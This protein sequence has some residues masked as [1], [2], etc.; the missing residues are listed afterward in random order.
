MAMHN[1]MHPGEFIRDVFLEP[2][3][4]STTKL[5][6]A[7]QVD[8]S[9]VSRILNGKATITPEMAIRLSASLGRSP[10]SWLNMQNNYD[11]ANA[12]QKVPAKTLVNL[13]AKEKALAVA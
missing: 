7:M 5:A 12:K 10:E 2:E 13:F 8:R 6:E 1:P 3:G 11:L 4:I 9:T